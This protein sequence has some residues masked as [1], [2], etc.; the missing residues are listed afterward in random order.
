MQTAS[1][2]PF[3][4]VVAHC[5]RVLLPTISHLGDYH[6]MVHKR[7][8]SFFF[9]KQLHGIPSLCLSYLFN[10]IPLADICFQSFARRELLDQRLHV[11]SFAR[12]CRI[13]LHGRHHVTYFCQQRMQV[14]LPPHT[15]SIQL[16]FS[17][18]DQYYLI[19]VDVSICKYF[20]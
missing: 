4:R 17:V 10:Q 12:W 1:H 8:S 11:S 20:W 15:G 13:A 2:L 18:V 19:L 16:V 5:I 7:A 3:S 14:P 6:I 9:F